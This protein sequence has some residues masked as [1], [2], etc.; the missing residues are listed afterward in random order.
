MFMYGTAMK[1]RIKAGLMDADDVAII[2]VLH[3]AASKWALKAGHPQAD[4]TQQHWMDKIFALKKA[5]VNIQLEICGVNMMGNHWTKADLYSYDEFGNPD[6]AAPGRIYVNQGAIGRVTD[7]QQRKFVY[8]NFWIKG[9]TQTVF[10]Q[11]YN[12]IYNDNQFQ[13]HNFFVD[14]V[15]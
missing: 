5:G 7:L 3:G 14:T 9:V 4:P 11:V 10:F 8:Y 13:N 1:N 6:P 12:D 15:R 2:G